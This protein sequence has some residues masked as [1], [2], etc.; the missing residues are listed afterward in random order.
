MLIF[1]DAGWELCYTT[2]IADDVIGNLNED[3][4][5][6][7]LNKIYKLNKRITNENIQD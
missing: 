7:I 1:S 5:V 4:V 2:S 3:D 6:E